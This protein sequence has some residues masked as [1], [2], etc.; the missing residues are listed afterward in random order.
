MSIHRDLTKIDISDAIYVIVESLL[1]RFTAHKVLVVSIRLNVENFDTGHI[2]N[3]DV[4]MVFYRPANYTFVGVPINGGNNTAGM[5]SSGS[6]VDIKKYSYHDSCWKSDGIEDIIRDTIKEIESEM[7]GE[8]GYH[9]F[10]SF[11]LTEIEQHNGDINI[12][13]YGKPSKYI[14]V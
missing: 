3:R 10:T 8:S 14:P 12:A 9:A 7:V 11:G 6:E 5:F 13:D 2:V 1:P 4:N